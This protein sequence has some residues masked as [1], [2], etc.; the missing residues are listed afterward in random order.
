MRKFFANIISAFFKNPQ[1]RHKVRNALTFGLV[2]Y[3]LAARRFRKTEH[4]LKFRYKLSITAIAKNEGAYFKEWIEYH[5]M[6][7]V[8]KFYIYDNESTDNTRSVLTPYMKSGLVEYKFWPGQRVQLQAY[9]DSIKKHKYATKWMAIIDLDEFLVPT[10]DGTIPEYLDKL[11]KNASQVL[12]GWAMYGSGGHLT[13]PSG[14]VIENFKTRAAENNFKLPGPAHKSVFN[15]RLVI[16]TSCHDQG[17]LDA[18]VQVRE[19]DGKISDWGIRCNHYH[20]KSWEEYQK[21]APR[22]TGRGGIAHG[23]KK[24][25]REFFDNCDHNEVSDPIMDKF[26]AP[27]KKRL[28]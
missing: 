16:A 15:P 6:L 21:R 22:G 23:A 19:C 4:K 24:Y 9:W 7:G 13:K 28:S 26:I 3:C 1:R 18:G 2:N 20:C 12:V 14:L 11:P 25:T 27:L 5:R 17:T 8:E 10:K